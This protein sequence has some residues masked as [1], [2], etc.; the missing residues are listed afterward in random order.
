MIATPYLQGDVLRSQWPR[1]NSEEWWACQVYPRLL[2]FDLVLSR[3]TDLKGAAPSIPE[4]IDGIPTE[5]EPGQP[6]P[7]DTDAEEVD[8]E[9]NT[10]PA[11]ESPSGSESGMSVGDDVARGEPERETAY[12]PVICVDCSYVPAMV[13]GHGFFGEPANAGG[14]SAE[15]KYSQEY[16]RLMTARNMTAATSCVQDTFTRVT[17]RA[18]TW[19]SG[20]LQAC[21]LSQATLFKKLDACE[22]DDAILHSKADFD[23]SSE[24]DAW[25]ERVNTAFD[26]LVTYEQQRPESPTRVL[27]AVFYLLENGILDVPDTKNINIKQGRAVLHAAACIQ[28]M[29]TKEWVESGKLQEE[30]LPAGIKD[31]WHRSDEFLATLAGAAGSGKTAVLKVIEKLFE[32]F[33]G[34]ESFLKSAPTNVAARLAGGDTA[35]ALYKLP[36]RCLRGKRGQLSSAMLQVQRRRFRGAKGHS[37]D[38][39]SMLTPQM[40][41][42]IDVRSRAAKNRPH[43]RYGGLRTWLIGDFL[44]LPPVRRPSLA[45]SVDELGKLLTDDVDGNGSE[46][47]DEYVKAEHRGGYDLW[48]QF[49][50]VTVLTLNMRSTG[51][52]AQILQQMREGALTDA[53]WDALQER[54]VGVIRQGKECVM[55]PAGTA[56]P[57]LAAP[58][59]STHPV[60]YVGHRHA[61]RTA[62]AYTNAVDASSEK[63]VPLYI[64]CA[65]DSV[66]DGDRGRY[67][68]AV[69]ERILR[70][71]N[72]RD[73]QNRPGFLPLFEGM[74][75][76]LFS[77][78][79]VRLGLMRGCECSVEAIKVAPQEQLPPATRLGEPLRLRYLPE[80]LVLRALG[81]EW[82]L[83]ESQLPPLP[84][85]VDRRGLFVIVPETV[86]LQ[87]NLGGK[88]G[89]LHVRRTQFAVI[90]ASARVSYG[91]Q[92]ETWDAVVGD[93]RRPPGMSDEI[94]WLSCYV[95]ISRARTLEGLLFTR[96]C[97]RKELEAG[98]PKYLVEEIDRLLHLEQTSTKAL[99]AYLRST[100]V[101]LP[102]AIRRL[103]DAAAL[104]AEAATCA[105]LPRYDALRA[106][107][108]VTSPMVLSR[109]SR[110]PVAS[111][112]HAST[113]RRMQG[114]QKAHVTSVTVPLAAPPAGSTSAGA[115]AAAPEAASTLVPAK[116][117]EQLSLHGAPSADDDATAE[118][119]GIGGEPLEAKRARLATAAVTRA[120]TAAHRGIG[121]ANRVDTM[122]RRADARERLA[123]LERAGKCPRVSAPS[124]PTAT[125][126]V[127][128]PSFSSSSSSSSCAVPPPPPPPAQ[129]SAPLASEQCNA[130]G[131]VGHADNTSLLCP[132]YGRARHPSNLSHL[133][134]Q[135]LEERDVA[136]LGRNFERRRVIR[137]TPREVVRG[138]PLP[139]DF[140]VQRAT[141][142][143][144]NCLIDTLRQAISDGLHANLPRI[145]KD[146]ALEFREGPDRVVTPAE[147]IPNFLELQTHWRA[148]IRLLGRHSYPAARLFCPERFKIICIDL[149]DKK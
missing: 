96:L 25:V 142:D 127:S 63:G 9:G 75:V 26:E 145:R 12:P 11:V 131:V 14:R 39:V 148:I 4:T 114:K 135:H 129:S 28:R 111:S 72:L 99:Y 34:P 40:N 6:V 22:I 23:V 76:L 56:D 112:P 89:K 3:R 78:D 74:R 8:A 30:T 37:I 43:E 33:F 48:R 61:I 83:P 13:R 106:P 110:T 68:D 82:T 87:V 65:A 60:Q 105:A 58:P 69:K 16:I 108:A 143:D 125:G 146:L 5:L 140:T 120:A 24:G 52:L 81:A 19:K 103:F 137:I 51:R 71:P 139:L 7:V 17:S 80:G 49:S 123:E 128:T 95:I 126:C 42:Q 115:T 107:E 64:V 119:S 20:C 21:A 101:P 98:A 94:L 141:G 88:D 134:Q 130:C 79:C 55:L 85:D 133:P 144:N 70:I 29:K 32:H 113:R 121:D 117:E 102:A 67:T 1:Y 27:E 73:T 77:K 45:S 41:Y 91:A 97:E 109:P 2:N 149:D 53:T 50:V 18:G 138:N 104:A 54:V 100:D 44:Q 84:E 46:K 90:P 66:R 31:T 62:Q 86:Y 132:Y 35:H 36:L 57:R 118:G 38:E 47:T 59:F 147:G 116:G 92:G 10:A 136:F 122:R 124:G 15:A 93:V